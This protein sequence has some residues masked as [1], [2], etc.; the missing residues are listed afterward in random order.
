MPQVEDDDAAR[1]GWQFQSA[2]LLTQRRLTVLLLCPL[3][4]K[5]YTGKGRDR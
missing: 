5:L 3:N 2:G 4:P 1:L